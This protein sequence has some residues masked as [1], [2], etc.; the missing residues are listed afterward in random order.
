MCLHYFLHHSLDKNIIIIIIIIYYIFINLIHTTAITTTACQKMNIT[1][2][3]IHKCED[4][5]KN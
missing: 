2:R 5:E 3:K 1:R 4:Q